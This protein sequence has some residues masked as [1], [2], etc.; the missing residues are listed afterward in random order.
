VLLELG[1]GQH[2]DLQQ[3]PVLPRLVGRMLSCEDQKQA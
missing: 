1:L 3:S 2:A